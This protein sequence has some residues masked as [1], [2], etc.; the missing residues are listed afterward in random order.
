MVLCLRHA[1]RSQRQSQCY[2]ICVL[3]LLH[4]LGGPVSASNTLKDLKDKVNA[5]KEMIQ[6][7]LSYWCMRPSATSLWGLKLLVYEA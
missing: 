6:V 5:V 7:T 3:I 1:Q 4:T 2:Y